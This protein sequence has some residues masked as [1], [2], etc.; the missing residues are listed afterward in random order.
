MIEK[1]IQEIIEYQNTIIKLNIGLR[2]DVKGIAPDQN[3]AFKYRNHRKAFNAL[4]AQIGAARV[5]VKLFS[6]FSFEFTT[7]G[8]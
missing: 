6:Q 7:E 1:Q 5:L 4:G 2:Q 8:E 3:G